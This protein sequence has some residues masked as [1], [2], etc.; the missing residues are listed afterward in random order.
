MMASKTETAVAKDLD[1]NSTGLKVP[2]ASSRVRG[3]A[4]FGLVT[5][6]T[7]FLGL[8]GWSATA[9]I[10]QAVTAPAT[11]LVKGDRKE[12]QHLEG[13]IVS[14][15]LV[16]EGQYVEKDQVLI[17]LR[18]LQADS[19]ASRIRNQMDQALARRDRLETELIGS[20][21][22]VM[23]P[24]LLA[25]IE[26]NPSALD[27]IE[28]EQLEFLARKDSIAGQVDILEQRIV[29]FNEQVTGLKILKES[30]LQQAKLLEIELKD[31]RILYEMMNMDL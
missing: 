9:P 14:R 13:G 5:V 26:R 11:L 22:I 10:D 30:R 29:Q 12:I 3:V 8:G 15:V 1:N 18:R 2:K 6:A 17:S 4:I 21:E 27:F 19:M 16:S 23:S 20:K 7:I 28:A 31:L 25:R 24:Q